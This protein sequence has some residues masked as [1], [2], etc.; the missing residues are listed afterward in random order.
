MTQIARDPLA[1][2]T[3]GAYLLGKLAVGP[4]KSA[5]SIAE[6]LRLE[7]LAPPPVDLPDPAAVTRDDPVRQISIALAAL[8]AGH[9]EL[10]VAGAYRALHAI[11]SLLDLGRL[12]DA[13]YAVAASLEAVRSRTQVDLGDLLILVAGMVREAEAQNLSE[14]ISKPS[15]LARIWTYIR[16]NG[17]LHDFVSWALGRLTPTTDPNSAGSLFGIDRAV[18][19]AAARE[20]TRELGYYCFEQRLDR[21]VI[22]T[23]TAFSLAAPATAVYA[24][25]APSQPAV[26]KLDAP[27]VAGFQLDAQAVFDNPAVQLL[28]MEPAF[29]IVAQDYLGA[30]AICIGPG[31]RWSLPVDATPNSTLAQQFHF[32]D[33]WFKWIRFFIYLTDV[34]EF[35]G[36]TTL[37][38]GTHRPGTK[39]QE[40]LDRGYQRIP[41]GDILRFHPG[42][43]HKAVLG[44]AGTTFAVD[45]AAWHKADKPSA[46]PRLILFITYANLVLANVDFNGR[47]L[48]LKATHSVAFRDFV[49]RNPWMF[50]ELCYDRS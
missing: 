36:P 32:D 16:C 11:V 35:S 23:L 18:V 14:P 40:L 21:T 50:P 17:R 15:H 30:P 25:G 5:K 20:S 46:R 34:D 38:R 45:T 42:A 22:D 3:L 44:P 33:G 24:D 6:L 13:C 28:L 26:P 1:L 48:M 39:P 27:N 8:D 19:R 47:R 7:K 29:Q 10:V 37:V 31:M 2:V 43:T 41:D 9:H 12:P 4:Q 49:A